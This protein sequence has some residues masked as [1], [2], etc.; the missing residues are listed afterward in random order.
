M[1]PLHGANSGL[2][3]LESWKPSPTEQTI[4]GFIQ[5]MKPAGGYAMELIRCAIYAIRIPPH[6]ES[7]DRSLKDNELKTR[8]ACHFPDN[9]RHQ[10]NVPQ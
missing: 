3:L 8:A 1:L 7:S 10:T 4:V 5:R 2:G 6:P 9:G